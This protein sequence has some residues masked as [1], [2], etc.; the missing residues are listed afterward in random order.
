MLN[1]WIKIKT[2][3]ALNKVSLALFLLSKKKKFKTI[4]KAYHSILVYYMLV[5]IS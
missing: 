2:S 5:S 4:F 3:I 1:K